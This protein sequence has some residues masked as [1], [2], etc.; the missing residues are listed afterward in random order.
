VPRE[1]L[2]GPIRKGGRNVALTSVAGSSRRRGLDA[3]TICVV[4]L[5]VN[6]LR[7]EPP[8]ADSEVIGIVQSISRYPAGSVRY[9]ASPA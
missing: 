6:R 9:I 7:C 3:G 4:L 2:G 1:I 5:E 8:L